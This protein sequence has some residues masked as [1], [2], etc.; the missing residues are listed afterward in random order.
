VATLTVEDKATTPT[1][2]IATIAGSV[3]FNI[4]TVFVVRM[5]LTYRGDWIAAGSIAGS[6][7]GSIDMALAK[8]LWW[9]YLETQ[10]FPVG[11]FASNPVA[12]PVTD[13]LDVVPTRCR[14]SIIDV[15]KLLNLPGIGGRV[16]DRLWFDEMN[17]SY[18]C[19][20]CTTDALA[21]DKREATS[22]PEIIGYP[23]RVEIAENA[24]ERIN[25]PARAPLWE[26]WRFSIS[27]ALSNLKLPGVPENIRTVVRP[28]NILES[29]QPD[30]KFKVVSGLIAT[31][32]C[33]VARGLGV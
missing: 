32:A 20:I 24:M 31:S 30:G 29:S 17:V 18:P 22:G 9:A 23:T 12:F 2:A 3:G 21:E 7:D 10:S 15:V 5:D 16:Y 6:G 26:A 33:R 11:L 25:D 14:R 13:G 19:V 4:H 1:G 27:Q 8:G 28:L